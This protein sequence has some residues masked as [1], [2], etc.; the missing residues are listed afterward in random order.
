MVTGGIGCGCSRG[1][2][3]DG[4][5]L[6]TSLLNLAEEGSIKIGIIVDDLTGGLSTDSCM[7]SVGVLGGRVITPDD[8]VL[9][10]FGMA[11]NLVSNLANS[12]ALVKSG[13]SAELRFGD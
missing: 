12:S 3:H 7:E 2:A 8:E 1:L 6:G 11:T 5:D 13:E 9:D 4:D 10:L